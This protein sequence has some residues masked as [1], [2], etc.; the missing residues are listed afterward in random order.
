MKTRDQIAAE[1]RSVVALASLPR[2]RTEAA[3]RLSHV[4]SKNSEVVTLGELGRVAHGADVDVTDLSAWLPAWSAWRS[5]RLLLWLNMLLAML[6]RRL[7]L[8]A[9]AVAS[10][11][12]LRF[13]LRLPHDGSRDGSF[14]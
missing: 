7:A 2:L 9:G 4:S 5:L 6:L 11:A 13:R 3:R 14:S 1:R 8:L 10:C 12:G